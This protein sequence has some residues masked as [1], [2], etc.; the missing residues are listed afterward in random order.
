MKLRVR[1]AGPISK[2]SIIRGGK[3][4]AQFAPTRATTRSLT[5]T[6]QIQRGVN[7]ITCAWSR[8][9]GIS[10]GVRQSGSTCLRFEV[11]PRMAWKLRAEDC[12]RKALANEVRTQEH[13]RAVLIESGQKIRLVHCRR[14]RTGTTAH[15]NLIGAGGFR[16]GCMTRVVFTVL[17]AAM[18]CS[19][20]QVEAGP[21]T[22]SVTT[23]A[24]GTLGASSFTNTPVSVT[25][26]GD[27]AN[28][29]AGS[30]PISGSFVNP[31]TATVNILGL[32]IATFTGSNGI[33]SG[34][35]FRGFRSSNRRLCWT[36]EQPDRFDGHIGARR[37]VFFG[38]RSSGS[39]RTGFRNRRF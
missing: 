26:T 21:I 8:P 19:P 39:T 35:F 30:G 14:A 28:V 38:L 6:L 10:P 29:V 17:A 11:T 15:T 3:Y 9:T 36:L 24:S 27:T 32:G 37:P 12:L 13:F 34:S 1:G 18:I 5:A 33:L 16:R 20:P 23:T 7:T 2:V 22:Y 31:G 4:L 25:L